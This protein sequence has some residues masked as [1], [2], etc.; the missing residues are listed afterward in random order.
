MNVTTRGTGALTVNL[1]DGVDKFTSAVAV[2]AGDSIDAGAGVDTLSLAL[3]GSA[4]IGAFAGF[5]VFDTA[6]LGTKTLD[7]D[8]LASKNTVTEFVA[9]G[10]IGG[11]ASLVNIGAGVGFRSTA[12]FTGTLN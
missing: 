5:D 4:N 11:V 12:D 7:V 3:V 10:N 1:G 6:A 8:I 9:S 2:T